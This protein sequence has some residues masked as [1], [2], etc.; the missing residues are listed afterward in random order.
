MDLGNVEKALTD[1]CQ[2]RQ[3]IENDKYCSQICITRVASIVAPEG[4]RLT[5]VE[6][7]EPD[8]NLTFL[9]V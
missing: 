1:W 3:L 5:L 8:E 2:S 4:V 7:A 6:L 9:P